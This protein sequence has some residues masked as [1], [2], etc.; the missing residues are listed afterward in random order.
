MKW[1]KRGT[2]AP[3]ES[4]LE[5]SVFSTSL[6]SGPYMI[7]PNR[8]GGAFASYQG[9]LLNDGRM[10]PNVSYAKAYCHGHASQHEGDRI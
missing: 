2:A 4:G 10:L 3:V 6:T 9:A 1:L 8:G 5:W 7:V